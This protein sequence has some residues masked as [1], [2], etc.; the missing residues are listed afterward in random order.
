M[1][2]RMHQNQTLKMAMMLEL[3]DQEFKTTRISRFRDPVEKVD[4]MYEHMGDIR[5]EMKLVRR[6]QKEMLKIENSV[7][8]R[9]PLM[10]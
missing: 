9:I 7:T 8:E 2:Q 3:S 6:T 1:R 4:S 10:S 5:L